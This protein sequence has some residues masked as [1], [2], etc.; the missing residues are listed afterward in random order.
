MR[1]LMCSLAMLIMVFLNAVAYS[2]PIVRDKIQLDY[3]GEVF[4][5]NS[6]LKLK[7]ALKQQYSHLSFQNLELQN[8]VMFAK[9]KNGNGKVQLKIGNFQSIKKRVLGTAFRNQHISTFDRIVFK[10]E[11]HGSDGVWQLKLKG[12]IRVN[13]VVLNL[14][15]VSQTKKIKIKLQ[16]SHIKLGRVVNLKQLLKQQYPRFDLHGKNLQKIIVTAK[17]KQGQGKLG[18]LTGIRVNQIKKIDGNRRDF[19]DNH[20]DTF[21]NIIL[22]NNSLNIQH[23]MYLVFMGNIKVKKIVLVFKNQRLSYGNDFFITLGD[24]L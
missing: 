2:R 24:S 9:S 3:Y 8:V 10:N 14:V 6:I 18:L 11:N 23:L 17:S 7:T 19:N 5:N 1:I 22:K 21:Y 4:R 13:K 20:A 16:N 12:N 15:R